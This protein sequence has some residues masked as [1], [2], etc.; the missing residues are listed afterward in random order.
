V[1]EANW[2]Y[3]QLAVGGT[4]VRQDV[5]RIRLLPRD[6][7][8]IMSAYTAN[9]LAEETRHEMLQR[10]L[11]AHDRGASVLIIEP[12]ARRTTPWWHAWEK[13]FAAAGGRADEWRFPASLPPRQRQLAKAAGLNLQELTARS[14][15]L[16]LTGPRS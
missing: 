12:I 14:L 15:Y 11:N 16:P 1:S 7:T 2:T 3:R 10:L 13:A 5:A 9:E 8:A 6:G 4:A